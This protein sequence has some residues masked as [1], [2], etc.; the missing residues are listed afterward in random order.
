VD[1]FADALWECV[2]A[3]PMKRAPDVAG[4]QVLRFGAMM[5][6]WKAA[7]GIRK[8]VIHLPL[9]APWPPPCAAATAPRRSTR[10]VA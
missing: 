2:A 4:P 3:G 10:W 9:P 5:R 8:P 1:E 7:R 6:A